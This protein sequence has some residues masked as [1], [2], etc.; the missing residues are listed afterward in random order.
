MKIKFINWIYWV[1]AFLP[2]IVTSVVFSAFPATIPAHFDAAGKVDRYGN[3]LELFIFPV[4]ILVIA[5]F[6]WIFFSVANKSTDYKNAKIVDVSKIIVIITFNVI[7][8]AFLLSTYNSVHAKENLDLFKIGAILICLGDIV[9]A[10]YLQKCKWN[11]F[12]GIRTKWTL[13]SEAV[14]CQ[15]HRFGGWL[16]AIGGIIICVIVAIFLK[17]IVCLYLVLAGEMIILVALI[18]YSYL[19]YKNVDTQNG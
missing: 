10:N 18:I 16:L 8:Y 14:W 11:G 2:L 13:A 1:L 3:K 19:S 9:L 15:T 7:S 4:T 5:L 12:T 17:G 6:F